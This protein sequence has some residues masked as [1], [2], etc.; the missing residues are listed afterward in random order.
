MCAFAESCRLN[1][2]GKAV[3][4]PGSELDAV[5]CVD[6]R[7]GSRDRQRRACAGPGN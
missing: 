1:V 4:V 7:E 3:M 2:W 5:L 6:T